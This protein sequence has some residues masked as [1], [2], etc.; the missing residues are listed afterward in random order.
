LTRSEQAAL[1]SGLA[2]TFGTSR[3]DGS[4]AKND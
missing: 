3:R 2:T 4:R 1:V